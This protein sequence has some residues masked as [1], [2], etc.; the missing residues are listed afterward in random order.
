MHAESSAA[1]N[2]QLT[3]TEGAALKLHRS[4]FR[5]SKLGS[6]PL[7]AVSLNTARGRLIHD[8]AARLLAGVADPDEPW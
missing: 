1:A 8:T 3:S 2:E 5:R 7:K 6:N 4:P